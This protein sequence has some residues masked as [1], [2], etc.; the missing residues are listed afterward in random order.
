MNDSKAS[1]V[2]DPIESSPKQYEVSELRL[3]SVFWALAVFVA[4]FLT[5]SARFSITVDGMSYLDIADAYFR[6]DWG[7]A[8]NAYWSPLYSWALGLGLWILKPS[9]YWQFPAV[10]FVNFLI[11]VLSLW[12]F[13]FFWSQQAQF[14]YADSSKTAE[15]CQTTLPLWAWFSL[16]YTLFIWSIARATI[17]SAVT[18]DLLVSAIVFLASGLIVRIRRGHN[19]FLTFLLLG[20]VLGVGYLCKSAMFVIGFVF[21]GV[22]FLA[23]GDVRKSVVRTCAALLVFLI[24]AAP[25]VIAISRSKHRFTI[26]DTAKINLAWGVNQSAPFFNWQGGDPR[27]GTP[28]HSTR[29]LLSVPAVYEFAYP[30]GGTYPPHYDP[31]Y[32]NEGL[33]PYFSLKQQLRALV[34]STYAFYSDF[35]VPQSGLLTG[36]LI[37]LFMSTNISA[38]LRRL[39]KNWHLWFLAVATIGMYSLVTLE[40]R[41]VGPFVILLWAAAL[42]AIQLP[43]SQFSKRLLTC[44][45]IFGIFTLML[46]TAEYFGSRIYEWR[47]RSTNGNWQIADGLLR[48]GIRQGQKVVSLGTA[49]NAY[50]ARLGQLKIVAEIP[51]SDVLTFWGGGRELQS[52]VI[53]VSRNT[54]AAAIVAS[55]VPG[56]AQ[57]PGWR[58]I[59]QT[60]F[61]VFLLPPAGLS[62]SQSSDSH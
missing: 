25:F 16:G 2:G 17:V 9:T 34:T 46:S 42:S 35:V 54:G 43:T 31:S 49:Y 3:R 15:S 44:V 51:S 36:V 33:T 55:E 7:M 21:L 37:A 20:L 60:G 48:M 41:Y 28:K 22:A 30:I 18:P 5:W 27:A 58:P 39:S 4:A 61:Y 38:A 26:G 1:I 45:A 50:W 8:I 57:L 13:D 56:G 23:V 59:G 53:E 47:Q 12:C 19:G 29:K 52:M 10:Q 14:L 11:C 62:N 6:R 32:W 40:H 24:V